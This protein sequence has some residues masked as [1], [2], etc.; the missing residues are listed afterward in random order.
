L[1]QQQANEEWKSK[2][3]FDRK[4]LVNNQVEAVLKKHF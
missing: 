3:G 4:S 2:N 1:A